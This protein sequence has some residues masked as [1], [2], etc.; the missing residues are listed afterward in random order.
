MRRCILPANGHFEWRPSEVGNEQYFIQI[1]GSGAALAGIYEMWR[2]VNPSGYQRGRWRTSVAVL[3]K[4]QNDALGKKSW[5]A[6]IP[7]APQLNNAW[8]SSEKTKADAALELIE[9]AR[10]FNS[11]NMVVCR[12]YPVNR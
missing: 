6:P 9:D 3:T 5:R 10:E 2:P 8:L 12:S 1:L 11:R 7:L 4:E